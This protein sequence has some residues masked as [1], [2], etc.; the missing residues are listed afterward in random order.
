[1]AN[2]EINRVSINSELTKTKGYV[3]P[4]EKWSNEFDKLLLSTIDETIRYVMGNSN[5]DI[6]FS[7]IEKNYCIIENIPKNLNHFSDGLRDLIGPGRNQMLGAA[8]IVEETIAEAFAMKIGQSFE[9]QSPINFPKYIQDL[10][11]AYISENQI[12]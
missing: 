8:C 9:A 7:Y 1:M 12:R 5:T 4:Q 11:R 3:D 10:K 2:R 6:I